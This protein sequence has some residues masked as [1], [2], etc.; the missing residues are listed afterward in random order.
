MHARRAETLVDVQFAVHSFKARRAEAHKLI[1]IARGVAASWA[2]RGGVRLFQEV[3]EWYVSRGVRT[4]SGTVY[5][6]VRSV[7]EVA[8]R[9][10]CNY[11]VTTCCACAIVCQS[12]NWLYIG[13]FRLVYTLCRART[14]ELVRVHRERSFAVRLWH[15]RAHWHAPL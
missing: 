15:Y 12:A 5:R 7:D 13:H 14:G 10:I 4:P 9:C 8:G 2:R 11:V 3:A 1:E 6:T